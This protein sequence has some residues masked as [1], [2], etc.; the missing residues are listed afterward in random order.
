MCLGW[1]CCKTLGTYSSIEAIPLLF[2]ACPL[3]LTVLRNCSQNC[4]HPLS[5]RWCNRYCHPVYYLL[6]YCPVLMVL[7]APCYFGQQ[8]QYVWTCD[9][10][11]VV[12]HQLWIICVVCYK[13]CSLILRD[14]V[15]Y[16]GCVV[17]V[18]LL[19][20]PPLRCPPLCHQLLYLCLVAS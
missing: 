2:C 13:S 17:A 7:C 1:S 12:Q 14:R 3:S 10:P 8:F 5:H 4:A 16:G 15:L 19:L 18:G 6:C 20:V 9:F 11:P